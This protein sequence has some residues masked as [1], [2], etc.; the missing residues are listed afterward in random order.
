[1]HSISWPYVKTRRIILT[2]RNNKTS[3]SCL[4]SARHEVDMMRRQQYPQEQTYKNERN[5]TRLHSEW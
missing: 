5:V 2:Q 1:M 4:D 3:T